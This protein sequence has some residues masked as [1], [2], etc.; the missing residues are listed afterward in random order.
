MDDA[1]PLRQ[2]GARFPRLQYLRQGTPVLRV[3][4]QKETGQT[5]WTQT[6]EYRERQ[7]NSAL[8]PEPAVP[9]DDGAH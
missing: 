5:P 3:T 6:L 4:L 9:A 1:Q 2:E 7:K 8:A